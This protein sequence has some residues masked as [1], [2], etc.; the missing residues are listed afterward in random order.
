MMV[1]QQPSESGRP[2]QFSLREMLYLIGGLAA[3]LALWRVGPL[4]A[5]VLAS[6]TLGR[7]AAGHMIGYLYGPMFAL[8]PVSLFVLIVLMPFRATGIESV[9]EMVTLV[10]LIIAGSIFGGWFARSQVR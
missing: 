6:A 8:L 9:V 7:F 10:A 5:V 4:P 2:F 3:A 1:D